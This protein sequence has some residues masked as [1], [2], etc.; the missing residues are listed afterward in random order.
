MPSWL[1][2]TALQHIIAA[3][4]Y[5]QRWNELFQRLGTRSLMMGPEMLGV[6]LDHAS[7]HLE[8]YLGVRGE[9]PKPFN[10]LEL[11]TGWYPTIAV[12]LYLC[13]ADNTW[14]VDIDPLIRT[15]QLKRMMELFCEF[16]SNGKLR[17]HLPRLREDRAARL[18]EFAANVDKDSPEGFLTRFGGKV[19]V[20]DAQKTDLPDG[21]IDLFFSTG[22]LEYIPSPVLHG[23]FKEFLRISKPNALMSHWIS[24]TD[25]FSY[26]DHSIGPYNYL[27]YSSKQWRYL[28]SPLIWQSR[29]RSSE[30]RQVIIEAGYEIVREEETRGSLEE[31]KKIRLAPE[32]ER[33]TL[34]DNRVLSSWIVANPKGQ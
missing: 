2:K 22:V 4:P 26:F 27:Q 21:S 33:Y 1:V 11:G 32:F 34:D 16:Q 31:F 5:R 29:L 24:L 20:R 10:V 23:I 9:L 6:R 12:G 3:L 7:R 15:P 13:G 30:Y 17:K 14:L 28:N 8:N 25:Q 19:M 18:S